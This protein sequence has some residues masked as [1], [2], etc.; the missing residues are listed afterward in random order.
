[1]KASVPS[2]TQIG[3]GGASKGL[4]KSEEKGTDPK[5]GTS[6]CSS[7][8]RRGIAF[9][10]HMKRRKRKYNLLDLQRKESGMSFQQAMKVIQL[11]L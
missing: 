6:S 11:R 2:T 1:M 8:A 3:K 9:S 10:T 5:R 4:Q 7:Q